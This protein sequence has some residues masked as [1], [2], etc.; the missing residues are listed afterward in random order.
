MGLRSF[1]SSFE[2][3]RSNLVEI[4]FLLLFSGP[5]VCSTGFCA[6]RWASLV[7]SAIPSFQF[8][9]TADSDTY[10]LYSLFVHSAVSCNVCT[11]VQY[12]LW[13]YANQGS[14]P[15]CRMYCHQVSKGG[16]ELSLILRTTSVDY[17]IRC[18]EIHDI[19]SFTYINMWINNEWKTNCKWIHFS[20]PHS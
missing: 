3:C 18:R 16:K 14:Y 7:F 15:R 11:V 20:P 17:Y 13:L 1:T 10:S 2:P 9:I 4:V 8:G 19:T 5:S 12:T 6:F